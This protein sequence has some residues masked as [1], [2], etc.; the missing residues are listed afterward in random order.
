AG[1][2]LPTQQEMADQARKEAEEVSARVDE[3]HKG[4]AASAKAAAPPPASVKAAAPVTASTKAAVPAPKAAG[5][6]E[7]QNPVALASDGKIPMEGTPWDSEQ[8]V[9]WTSEETVFTWDLGKEMTVSSVTLQVDNNDDYA[10]EYSRDGK[11]YE[12]LFTITADMGNIEPGMDT[13]SSDPNDRQYDAA[14]AF[15]PV[16]ARYLRLRAVSGDGAYAVSELSAN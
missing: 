4:M 5:K 12:K 8:C 14:L 13:F 7:F 15:E 9:F 10:V 2:P 6:G 3:A 11:K 1:V 16:K